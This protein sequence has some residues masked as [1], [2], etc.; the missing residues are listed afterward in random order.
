MDSSTRLFGA[1]GARTGLCLAPISTSGKGY[2]ARGILHESQFA[3]GA[4][5]RAWGVVGFFGGLLR[6]V[7]L[8]QERWEGK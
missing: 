2:N 7:D 8:S 1:E 6:S 5:H 4:D 3:V